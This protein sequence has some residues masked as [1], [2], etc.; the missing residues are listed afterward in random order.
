L[1]C[2]GSCLCGTVSFNLN[3]E[4][5]RFYTCHCSRCQKETGSAFASNLFFPVESIEWISG[6][7][8][9][10]RYEHDEAQFFCS[11][12]CSKCGSQVPYLSR[13]GEFHIVPAGSL[14]DEPEIHSSARI[15]WKD[16]PAWM[17]EALHAEAYDEYWDA[18]AT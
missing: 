8:D 18:D 2:S 11:D 17:D 15:F 6:H 9:V 5:L 14:D 10:T 4:L 13:N 1:I 12:F 3:G 16:R 7:D